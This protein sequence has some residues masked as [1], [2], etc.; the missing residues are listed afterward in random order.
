M[1]RRVWRDGDVWWEGMGPAP[2]GKLIDWKGNPW[3]A[4]SK[5]P[6]AHPNS[7]FTAPAS[8]P[9]CCSRS[10]REESSMLWVFAV[11]LLVLWALGMV[12]AYTLGGALHVLLAAAL[13][14]GVVQVIPARRTRP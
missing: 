1:A 11:L 3:E 6:A 2:K 7:R 13:V 4:G 9:R 5:E 8:W 14:V 10:G 12:T